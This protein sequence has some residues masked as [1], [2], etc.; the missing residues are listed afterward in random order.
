MRHNTLLVG[1]ESGKVISFPFPENLTAPQFT[2]EAQR[3]LAMLSSKA[4]GPYRGSERPPYPP[5][6]RRPCAESSETLY[7]RGRWKRFKPL[8]AES[9]RT[10]P[11]CWPLGAVKALSGCLGASQGA[12]V[13]G[14]ALRRCDAQAIELS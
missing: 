12:G 14:R 10:W 9:A 5:H 6:A 4:F 1:C 11:S 8:F 13:G 3:C 7:K 2:D